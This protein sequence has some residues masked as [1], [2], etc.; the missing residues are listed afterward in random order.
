MTT[1]ASQVPGK[2][3]TVQI[4]LESR[5]SLTIEWEAPTITGDLPFTR[6]LI[7]TDEADYVLGDPIDNDLLLEYTKTIAAEGEG[8]IFRFRVAVENM[9]GIG[10]YSDEI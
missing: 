2:I 9:L 6:Y 1:T 8:K 5:T 3:D 10:V 7:R 4:K